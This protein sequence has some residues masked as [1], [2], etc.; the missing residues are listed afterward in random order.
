MGRRHGSGWRRG[1][2]WH[3]AMQEAM[4]QGE[5][6]EHGIGAV[7]EVLAE[8]FLYPT[9]KTRDLPRQPRHAPLDCGRPR[10]KHVP[11]WPCCSWDEAHLACAYGQ[12]S[13]L[14]P[15]ASQ[16]QGPSDMPGGWAEDERNAFTAEG[17]PGRAPWFNH[18]KGLLGIRTLPTRLS[19]WHGTLLPQARRLWLHAGTGRRSHCHPRQCC[20]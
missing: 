19:R 8:D 5:G 16:T 2:A 15:D 10:R 4:E 6:W 1:L 14:T 11:D 18:I 7:Y 12:N 13:G 3:F 9:P 17:R 20:G